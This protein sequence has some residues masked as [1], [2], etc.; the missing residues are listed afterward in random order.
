MAYAGSKA[1]RLT[2]SACHT[3]NLARASLIDEIIV[4]G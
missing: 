3:E 2:K 4:I 1:E